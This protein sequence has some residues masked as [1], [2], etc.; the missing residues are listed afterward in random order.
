MMSLGP[1]DD[2][3]KLPPSSDKPLYHKMPDGEVAVKG[4]SSYYQFSTVVELQRNQRAISD[5]QEDLRSLL[6]TLRGGKS[7]KTD[8]EV[9]LSRNPPVMDSTYLEPFYVKLFWK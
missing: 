4:F 7:T 3:A 5:S 9:L 1:L 8:W 2:I 6:V